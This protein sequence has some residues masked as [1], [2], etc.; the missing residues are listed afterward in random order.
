MLQ[1][2]KG[3]WKLWKIGFDLQSCDDVYLL[4]GA[5]KYFLYAERKE[6]QEAE[7]ASIVEPK[8]L[9]RPRIIQRLPQFSEAVHARIREIRVL[10]DS[11]L[12]GIRPVSKKKPLAPKENF[13][14]PRF[15]PDGSFLRNNEALF[16]T[17]TGNIPGIDHC[18]ES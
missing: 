4:Q 7:Q 6:I 13:D 5:L 15:R 18:N 8:Y 2:M 17:F 16:L 9:R 14:A 12:S 11:K 10:Q 3:C 1:Y